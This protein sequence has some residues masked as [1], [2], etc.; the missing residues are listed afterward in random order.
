M[1]RR[2][3]LKAG[4]VLAST[5]H[6]A[7]AE[8]P[9]IEAPENAHAKLKRLA[10]EI[11]D[12]LNGLEP[13]YD[14]VTIQPSA[15]GKSAV[16]FMFNIEQEI[17]QLPDPIIAAIQDF[18]NGCAR[19]NATRDTVTHENEEEI[20][21]ATY[22]PAQD[23]LTDWNEPAHTREGAIA[24]LEFMK[25]QNVFIDDTGEGMR[26]AVLGYLEGLV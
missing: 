14:Y 5:S 15:V 6:T 11:S 1:D 18:H 10:W 26:K 4:L 24:A 13:S 12:L 3:V 19:F 2:T 20:V 17:V 21:Q 16:L 23:R 8:A 22:G 25:E 9:A 7:I